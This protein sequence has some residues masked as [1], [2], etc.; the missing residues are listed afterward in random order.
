MKLWR[1]VLSLMTNQHDVY[2]H[3][4]HQKM[5]TTELIIAVLPWEVCDLL[6]TRRPTADEK[7]SCITMNESCITM[8]FKNC[9]NSPLV[10]LEASRS[11]IEIGSEKKR[12]CAQS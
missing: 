7:E 2:Q 9:E 5:S 11:K 3:I 6:C 10:F 4:S 8:S 1:V 12:F